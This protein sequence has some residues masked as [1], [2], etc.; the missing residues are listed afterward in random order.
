MEIS[1]S[2]CPNGPWTA[3]DGSE[4]SDMCLCNLKKNI[5]NKIKKSLPIDPNFEDHAIGNTHIFL[6]GLTT[7]T[8]LS[9]LGNI[10]KNIIGL[11]AVFLDN[12][13]NGHPN[14]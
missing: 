7:P 5:K 2:S 10:K 8:Q 12:Y 6:F 3:L 13:Q 11:T 1:L 9:F 14:I 4:S